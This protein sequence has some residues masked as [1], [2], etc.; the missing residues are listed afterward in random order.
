MNKQ[1]LLF[2]LEEPVANLEQFQ[3]TKKFAD[4]RFRNRLTGT[5]ASFLSLSK[6]PGLE[7]FFSYMKQI[8]FSS[9]ITS[10]NVILMT[11]PLMGVARARGLENPQDDSPV[12]PG[13]FYTFPTGPL[14]IDSRFLGVCLM[15][16]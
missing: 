1:I 2:P 15:V 14:P 16:W 4:I 7:T 3:L 5:Y 8:S 10:N 9:F 12:S 11:I 6:K 13:S